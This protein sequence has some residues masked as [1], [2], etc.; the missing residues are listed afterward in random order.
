MMDAAGT[1]TAVVLRLTRTVYST[2]IAASGLGVGRKLAF[3]VD[4][5]V[6]TGQRLASL[7]EACGKRLGGN[8]IDSSL[9]PP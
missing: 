2:W 4:H 5:A 8:P 3:R 9:R 7:T 1:E 6:V